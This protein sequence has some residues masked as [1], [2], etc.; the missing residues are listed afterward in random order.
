MAMPT[1]PPKPPSRGNSQQQV[2]PHEVAQQK[3][4]PR[5]MHPAVQEAMG[6]Y[7]A[8]WEENDELR[9]ENGKFEKDNEV[10]RK[11]DQE[12]SALIVSLRSALEEAQK[13]TDA[14]LSKQEA[15]FRERLAESERAKE[16]YLRYAV[17]ISERIQGCISDLQVANDSA[18]DMARSPSEQTLDEVQKAI[19]AASMENVDQHHR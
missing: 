18:M 2:V 13:T 17:A 1:P 6:R 3:A 16:R 14:R 7:A 19:S 8:I 4:R 5:E 9:V 10:L 15:Y 11:L 12:K